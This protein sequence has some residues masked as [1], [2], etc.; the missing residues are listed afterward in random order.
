VA[1]E[2]KNPTPFPGQITTAYPEETRFLARIF[3]DTTTSYKYFWFLALLSLI[4]RTQRRSFSLPELAAEMAVAA[5]HPVNLFRLSLGIQDKLQDTVK[6]IQQSSGVL[7]NASPDAIRDHLA[8]SPS[9]QQKLRPFRR[10]VPTRL[11]SPWFTEALRRIPDARK[12]PLVK[13]RARESQQT[14]RPSLYFFEGE[15]Q[16]EAITLNDRWQLFLSE[17]IGIVQQFAE[18]SLAQYLQARNPNVPGIINKLHAP[19]DRNLGGARKHLL[20]VH[21]ALVAAGRSSCFRDIYTEQSLGADF[22]IDHFLPWSFVA[23]NQFWNLTPVAHPV[24]SS[25]GDSLPHLGLY[26]PRLAQFHFAVIGRAKSSSRFLEDYANV[27]RQDISSLLALGE[28][29]FVL[30]YRKL[31]E[32]QELIAR[33]L[34]FPAGWR[35][36]G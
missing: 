31:I 10:F 18:H 15:S 2:V 26:L 20:S 24:N 28:A 11:L 12:D 8:A 33:N 25:K 6:L 36:L 30:K 34:G 21:A 23:H 29:G 14:S 13:K 5:W 17:N 7:P 16:V 32:P 3:D 22:S 19:A 9:D 27:F 35:F 4:R 1:G